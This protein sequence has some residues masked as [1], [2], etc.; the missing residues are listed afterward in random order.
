[1]VFWTGRRPRLQQFETSI[2]Q[3]LDA[4][5]RASVLLED[6]RPENQSRVIE[7][8]GRLPAHLD[9]MAAAA[10][11]PEVAELRVP[12]QLIDF[13]DAGTNPDLLTR[14]LLDAAVTQSERC[15]GKVEALADYEAALQREALSAFPELAAHLQAS[16]EAA[17]SSS[18]GEA[19]KRAKTSQ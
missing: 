4:L 15:K 18:N 6:Y 19:S 2:E 10:A 17:S 14:Q 9:A 13:V 1:M 3:L 12:R 16:E 5:N 7:A 8:V 11:T